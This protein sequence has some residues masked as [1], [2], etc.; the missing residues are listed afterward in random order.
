MVARPIR[1]YIRI[2]MPTLAQLCG[3]Q[4]DTKELDGTSLVPRNA[5]QIDACRQ[6]IQDIHT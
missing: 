1:L 5:D 2:G 4:L 6:I 3:I